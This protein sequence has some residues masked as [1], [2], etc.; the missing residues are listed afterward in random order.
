MFKCTHCG[1]KIN[2][3]TEP[4]NCPGCGNATGFVPCDHYPELISRVCNACE[5]L[6][7]TQDTTGVCPEC[8]QLA[9]F[10]EP[11]DA[12]GEGLEV[13]DRYAGRPVKV[14]PNNL[15]LNDPETGFNTIIEDDHE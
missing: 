3:E 15:L 13:V 12:P 9:V 11:E 1:I 8:G 14:D 6:V 10:T 5:A 7:F 2:S 4:V